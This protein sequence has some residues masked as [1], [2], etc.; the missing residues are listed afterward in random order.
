MKRSS[1]SFRRAEAAAL[2]ALACLASAGCVLPGTHQA[3]LDERDALAEER[4]L[5]DRRVTTLEATN[6]SLSNE[7]VKLIEEVETLR[8]EFDTLTEQVAG[9]EARRSEL[10]TQVASQEAELV[11]AS[12]EVS[13]LRS[14]Y[15]G[16]VQD[17]QDEVASGRIEI[18][19]LREGIRVKLAQAILFPTGS[20][21][22]SAKGSEILAKVG[23]RLRGGSEQIQVQGHT[24]DRKIHGRLART[25]PSNWE[26]GGARAGAVVRL[27]EAQGLST[28]RLVAVSYGETRPIAP[29]DP[30]H[31]EQNRRIEIRLV[32]VDGPALVQTGPEEAPDV[33]APAPAPPE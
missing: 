23:E 2:G 3:V 11:E 19:Q 27:L 15:D 14:T 30:E 22:I 17:L 12:G 13:A 16:L 24:D 21:E 26:L 10:E 1:T 20:A 9:L 29:N 5:L 25:Y 18:E 31:R 4:A 6:E 32:P 8:D 28:E 7:R 33:A